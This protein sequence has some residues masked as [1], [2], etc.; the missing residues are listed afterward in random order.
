[1]NHYNDASALFNNNFYDILKN[2]TSYSIKNTKLTNLPTSLNLF[3]NTELPTINLTR[4]V[5]LSEKTES[6]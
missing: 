2:E 4:L 1:M 5:D 6:E 3:Y